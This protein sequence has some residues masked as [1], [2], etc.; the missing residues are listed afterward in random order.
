MFPIALRYNCDGHDE[1]AQTYLTAIEEIFKKLP[2]T[3]ESQ[4]DEEKS[5]WLI[6]TNVFERSCYL[7]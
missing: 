5:L 4:A 1:N 3:L 6:K 7:F 2:I